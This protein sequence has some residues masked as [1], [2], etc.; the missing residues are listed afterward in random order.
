MKTINFMKAKV[1]L[2]NSRIFDAL[3]LLFTTTIMVKVKKKLKAILEMRH[4]V[5]LK[6]LK[7]VF[8]VVFTV[9]E[10]VEL[11]EKV[12]MVLLLS[13]NLYLYGFISLIIWLLLLKAFVFSR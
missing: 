7:S 10:G 11:L 4:G 9:V 1:D 5:I 2:I 12:I 6:V 13:F 8:K 3:T